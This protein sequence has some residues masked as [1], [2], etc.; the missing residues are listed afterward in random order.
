MIVAHEGDHHD[1]GLA[2]LKGVDRTDRCIVLALDCEAGEMRKPAAAL[3]L[4]TSSEAAN[5]LAVRCE[6]RER[7]LVFVVA[8]GR[9]R[10]STVVTASTSS[11]LWYRG[12]RSINCRPSVL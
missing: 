1:V 6:H 4:D 7:W 5:L 9:R 12:C 2:S 3:V 11:G 10:E 8:F